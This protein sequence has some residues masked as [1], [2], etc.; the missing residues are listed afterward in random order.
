M[1]WNWKNTQLELAKSV[2]KR[3]DILEEDLVGEDET[4][5]CP[6]CGKKC[7]GR[8]SIKQHIAQASGHPQEN[9]SYGWF[10]SER[11]IHE[12]IAK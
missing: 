12:Q 9:S 5:E 4:V 3:Y 6:E 1:V 10:L 7:N 2:K 11:Q 8:E